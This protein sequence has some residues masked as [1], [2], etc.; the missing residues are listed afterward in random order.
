MRRVLW[1][2]AG[3]LCLSFVAVA[4]FWGGSGE[5]PDSTASKAGSEPA[6]A[7]G[8]AAEFLSANWNVNAKPAP[9]RKRREDDTSSALPPTFKKFKG[10][11]FAPVAP[12]EE[13]KR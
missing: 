1:I 3:L 11:E 2:C 8:D 9:K 13:K 10:V 6:G 5:T 12:P 4:L 7:S